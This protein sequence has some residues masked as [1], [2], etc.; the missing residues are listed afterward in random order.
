[1]G[2]YLTQVASLYKGG[3]DTQGYIHE[4]A[5]LKR[6]KQQTSEL[7]PDVHGIVSLLKRWVMGNHQGAVSRKHLDYCL[8]EFTF[9]FNRRK[10]ASRGGLF[11]RLVEQ[12][13]AVEHT[14]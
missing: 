5:V 3:L 7:F 1:V 11:L 10:A 2:L 13:V 8:D 9:H 12:A 4:V 14:V 6:R